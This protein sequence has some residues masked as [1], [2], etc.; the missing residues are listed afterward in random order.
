VG[1]LLQDYF[2]GITAAGLLP[3][4]GCCRIIDW[5][6][7][8]WRVLLAGICYQWAKPADS[9]QGF[10][11]EWMSICRVMTHVDNHLQLVKKDN[12]YVIQERWFIMNALTFV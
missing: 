5:G 4:D 3:Q 2:L 9:S 6:L 1:G 7:L 8:L 11:T 10:A 12:H